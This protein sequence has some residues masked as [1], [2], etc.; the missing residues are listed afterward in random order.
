MKNQISEKS[1][2]EKKSE[3]KEKITEFSPH[4]LMA[5]YVFSELKQL[6]NKSDVS[7][8]IRPLH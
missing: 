8:Y 5:S 6:G 2:S 1:E 7:E 3:S 4:M